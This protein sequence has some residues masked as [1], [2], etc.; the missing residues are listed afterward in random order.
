MLLWPCTPDSYLYEGCSNS[1][2]A[3]AEKPKKIDW[4]FLRANK[5]ELERER[6][7]GKFVVITHREKVHLKCLCSHVCVSDMLTHAHTCTHMLTHKCAHACMHAH[8]HAHAHAHTSN[9][10]THT[11]T[12]THTTHT[13][14]THTHTHTPH[15]H[16][17]H[18]HTHT[19]T[20]SPCDKILFSLKVTASL[21]NVLNLL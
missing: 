9:T 2:A 15:I 17:T 8:A 21:Q 13:P 14:H 12:H 10:H 1:F 5:E 16:H 6:F 20:H 4:A 11:H 7:A 3:E 19:H 18:T